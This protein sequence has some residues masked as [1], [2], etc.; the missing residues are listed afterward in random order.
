MKVE[1]L[2]WDGGDSLWEQ[3]INRNAVNGTI[4]QLVELMTVNHPVVGSSPTCSANLN[5]LWCNGSTTDF[6]SVRLG[7]SPSSP[8]P[9]LLWA[10]SFQN[11]TAISC[12]TSSSFC[13]V[14]VP[15][16]IKKIFN[17]SRDDLSLS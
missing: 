16:S 10:I 8:T 12:E 9:K 5:G 14:F 1:H 7:S 3:S 13:I 15:I 6:G 2:L 17:I 4:A 11:L